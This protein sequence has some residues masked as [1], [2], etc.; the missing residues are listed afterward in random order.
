VT[1]SR[2]RHAPRAAS[3]EP[4][5]DAQRRSIRERLALTEWIEV[6][7]I[8]AVLAFVVSVPLLYSAARGVD[9]VRP[10]VIG[11]VAVLVP[12]LLLA[13]WLLSEHFWNVADTLES[14]RR[15]REYGVLVYAGG[16][17]SIASARESDIKNATNYVNQALGEAF[18]GKPISAAA[19]RA[20]GCSI[21]YK[22]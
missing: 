10:W 8:F 9:V 15:R 17:D 22:T 12:L 2:A 20:Y 13:A 6:V 1:P 18:G 3:V 4:S 16:I 14:R 19:T 11:V 7:V 21:K 5:V